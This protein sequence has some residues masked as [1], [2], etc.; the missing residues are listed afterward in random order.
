MPKVATK[1][2]TDDLYETDF[3][4][5]TQEQARLL[6]EKRWADLDLDNLVEEVESVGR[7]DKYQIES[8]L[9]VLIAH[10]LKWKFQPGLRGG[11]WAGTITVQRQGIARVTKSSP[12]LKRYPAKTYQDQYL[13]ARLLA[14]KETGIAFDLFPEDCP[15]TIDEVLDIDFFPDEPGHIGAGGG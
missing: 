3:H 11:S 7:S 9:E 13:A 14:S 2:P 6:K 8:R 15:F 4:A 1:A 5:W 10:L 12:S